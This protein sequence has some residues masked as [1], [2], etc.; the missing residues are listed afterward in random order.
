MT[1]KKIGRP[2]AEWQKK[3]LKLKNS[4]ERTTSLDQLEEM[5]GVDRRN[6]SCTLSRL[7]ESKREV[8]YNTQELYEAIK[9]KLEGENT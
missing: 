7:V 1:E 6:L 3:I 8:L 4:K 9:K 5:T 2:K